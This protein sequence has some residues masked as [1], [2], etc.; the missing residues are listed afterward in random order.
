VRDAPIDG[1]IRKS[2]SA[3][4]RR[5]PDHYVDENLM[6][7]YLEASLSPQE[8]SAFEAHVSD[9][10]VCQEL[11]AVYMKLHPHEGD[12]L[13]NAALSEK[14]TLF[15]F[16]IPIPALG[17][18]L[19]C[20]VIAAVF[21]RFQ[22]QTPESAGKDQVAELQAPVQ[23]PEAQSAEPRE[24]LSQA[25]SSPAPRTAAPNIAQTDAA[26]MEKKGTAGGSIDVL[27]ARLDKLAEAIPSQISPP[28]PVPVSASI[29][30]GALP[31]AD[32]ILESEQKKEQGAVVSARTNEWTAVAAISDSKAKT[33]TNAGG[34][35]V[36]LQDKPSET[37]VYEALA[38]A[39]A[40]VPE[41]SKADMTSAADRNLESKPGK[42]GG[43]VAPV[44]ADERD[45]VVS[46]RT[47]QPLSRP[48]I[49]AAQNRIATSLYT[50]SS[51]ESTLRFAI[52]NLDP[53]IK[54]AES[55]AIADRVYIKNLG[56]WIDKQ[57]TEHAE[58]EIV[59]LAPEAPEY[60]AILAQYPG[61][62]AI[63]PVLVYWQGMICVFR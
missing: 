27:G 3:G 4:V 17:V 25:V 50:T 53:N 47:Q 8:M 19:V 1:L 38:A 35:P 55:K 20:A 11:L 22:N 59:E 41:P 52:K 28:A 62:K 9:C 30:A 43:A 46:I 21:F 40:A 24:K 7:A 31:A 23:Q 15:R 14:K 60:K 16:S 32:S 54:S 29:A 61:L 63:F 10:A 26:G 58:S 56:Y 12:D 49:Y 45:A 37:A 5:A 48:R 13:P 34:V 51:V 33:E 39:P 18:L 36:A 42:D 57:C 2:L 6:A 44:A